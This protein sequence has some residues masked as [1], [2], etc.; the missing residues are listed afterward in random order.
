MLTHNRPMRRG[1]LKRRSPF[2]TRRQPTDRASRLATQI[3]PGY[4]LRPRPVV[5]VPVLAEA[6][7]AASVPKISALQNEQYMAAVRKLPCARCGVAGV[8]QFAHADQGKGMAI[9]TDCRLGWP[10]C[11][12]VGVTPG[13]H[14]LIG[15]SGRF[16]RADRREFERLAGDAT[17]AQIRALG[18]WPKSLPA[19]AA[20]EAMA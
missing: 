15:T 3:G 17:R 9:K 20:D 19:W 14:W 5:E 6:T 16:S 2:S 10:G 7:I 8:T 4:T 13:C 11:G 12:P 1:E 18:Q